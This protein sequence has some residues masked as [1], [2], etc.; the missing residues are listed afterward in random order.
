VET[1]YG[2]LALLSLATDRY[3]RLDPASGM[4]SADH[5]GPERGRADGAQF[6]WAVRPGARAPSVT[7]VRIGPRP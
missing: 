5:P 3:L 2:D 6:R 7:A 4:L 1:P